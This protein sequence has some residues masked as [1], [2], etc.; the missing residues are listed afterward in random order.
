MEFSKSDARF[1]DQV[2]DPVAVC[3]VMD[4]VVAYLAKHSENGT[5]IAERKVQRAVHAWDCGPGV[6]ERALRA[7]AF[8]E[9][10]ERTKVGRKWF[11]R[12]R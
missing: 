1:T 8:N 9:K 5:A 7:L 11:V 4:R 12:L 3:R 6:A 2:L 10:I